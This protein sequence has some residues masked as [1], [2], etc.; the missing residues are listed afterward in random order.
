MSAMTQPPFHGRN[1]LI[2]LKLGSGE[3]LVNASKES[4]AGSGRELERLKKVGLSM[5]AERDDVPLQQFS[6]LFIHV[7]ELHPGTVLRGCD[8]N[9]NTILSYDKN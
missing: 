6:I 3:R 5:A 9:K 1:F 8:D 7:G 4:R 2:C